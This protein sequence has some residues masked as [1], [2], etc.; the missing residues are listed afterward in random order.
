VG[1][2]PLGRCAYVPQPAFGLVE[3]DWK[4]RRVDLSIRD[5]ASGKVAIGKDGSKQLV[6]FDLDTC[7]RV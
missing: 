4:R 7:E 2:R 6:A 3:V 5:A 1:L